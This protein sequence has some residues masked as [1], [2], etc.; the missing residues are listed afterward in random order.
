MWAVVLVPMWLR[1]HDENN[2]SRSVRFSRALGSLSSRLDRGDRHD[3]ADTVVIA[4]RGKVPA[5][6]AVLMPAGRPERRT[7]R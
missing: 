4:A 6:R 3:G 5:G 7:T 2:E 1:K